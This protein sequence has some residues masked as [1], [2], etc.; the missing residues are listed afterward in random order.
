MTFLPKN[1]SY[2]NSNSYAKPLFWEPAFY[3]ISEQFYLFKFTIVT[4][5]SEAKCV[6]G[7]GGFLSMDSCPKIKFYNL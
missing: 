1:C 5:F 7:E 6:L 4:V 2:K 3:S